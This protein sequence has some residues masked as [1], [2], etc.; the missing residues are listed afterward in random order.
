MEDP[1]K[2]FRVLVKF[3]N[4]EYVDSFMNDGLLFMNNIDYFRKY[5]DADEALRGDEHEGL[6][7]SYKPESTTI[8]IG[9]HEVMGAVGKID[10]R[11]NHT[12]DT[13][14][15]SMTKISDGKILESGSS[16]L[17]L[18]NNFEKFGNKAVLIG[19]SNI[20]EFEKRL[21]AEVLKRKDICVL[22]N[23]NILAKQVE[24]LDRNEHLPNLSVFNKFSN[25][26]WQHEW[27]IAFKQNSNAGA[28]RLNLGSLA[29]IAVVLDTKELI[30]QPLKLIRN[31]QQVVA[32]PLRHFV[33][34]LDSF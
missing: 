10:I 6:S 26:S 1:N 24:Y 8:H 18:S 4:E 27:R 12:G 22:E 33:P 28:Y 30:S 9:S 34:A 15:Y 17:F 32:A 11:L 20:T 16:G 21:K 7:A 29:D 25:Y 14:I 2:I 5:E 23:E 13:N 19:G 31:L 3:M